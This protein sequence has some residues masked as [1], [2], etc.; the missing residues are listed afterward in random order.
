MTGA[1]PV[2]DTM[3]V[4][5][6]PHPGCVVPSGTKCMSNISSLTGRRMLRDTV[7]S[8]S[9]KSLTG[10][11]RPVI[12]SDNY[13]NQTVAN[14][15]PIS[16]RSTKNDFGR[17][18]RYGRVIGSIYYSNQTMENDVN[19]PSLSWSSALSSKGTQISLPL[20]PYSRALSSL[21]SY[22]SRIFYL[23]GSSVYFCRKYFINRLKYDI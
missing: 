17:P 14:D 11:N 15:T 4:E 13:N 21:M 19:I 20:F 10:L 22:L 23:F 16:F 12:G 2:R 5:N 1:C 8:T 3:L 6:V 7:S 18:K 9:I